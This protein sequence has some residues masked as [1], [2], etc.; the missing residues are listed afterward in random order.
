MLVIDLRVPPHHVNI[1]HDFRQWDIESSRYVLKKLK[2]F[3]SQIIS[4][5]NNNQR[6]NTVGKDISEIGYIR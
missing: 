3:I 5:D 1:Y 2:I 4:L 6:D